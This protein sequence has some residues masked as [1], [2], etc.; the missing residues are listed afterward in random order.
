VRFTSFGLCFQALP[1]SRRLSW[2]SYVRFYSNKIPSSSD[3]VSN[4]AKSEDPNMQGICSRET[5]HPMSFPSSLDKALLYI[6]MRSSAT[7]SQKSS[8]SSVRHSR[9]IYIDSHSCAANISN[10]YN[11]YRY[12]HNFLISNRCHS[13]VNHL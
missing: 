2:S 8:T 12:V 9:T 13:H 11:R 4:G 5:A 3:L 1:P 6:R 10:N 7:S